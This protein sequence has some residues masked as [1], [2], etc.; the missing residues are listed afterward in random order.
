MASTCIPVCV[1]RLLVF[2]IYHATADR[3]SRIDFEVYRVMFSAQTQPNASKLIRQCFT[4]Q[5]DNDLK[6]IAKTTQ[7]LLQPNKGHILDWPSRSSDLIPTEQLL[8][9]GNDDK[10]SHKPAAPKGDCSKGLAALC[11]DIFM[12]NVYQPVYQHQICF[13]QKL[14][15]APAMHLQATLQ[16]PPQFLL[17]MLQYV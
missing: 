15:T 9:Y 5:M 14:I 8:C 3:S 6:F 16:P 2:F 17:F 12:Y 10:E 4:V 11:M 7:Q 1:T 13:P